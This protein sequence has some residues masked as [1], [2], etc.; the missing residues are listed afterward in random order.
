[1]PGRKDPLKRPACPVDDSGVVPG[2]GVA[3]TVGKRTPRVPQHKTFPRIVEPCL[4]YARDHDPLS[5]RP[6][7]SGK[8][9]KYHRVLRDNRASPRK[10]ERGD[11]REDKRFR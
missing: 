1:M 8:E 3:N 7:E 6:G 10:E 9:S 4:P 2:G 11:A 5:I